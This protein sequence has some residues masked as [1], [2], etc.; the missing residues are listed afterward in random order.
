[1]RRIVSSDRDEDRRLISALFDQN[2]YLATYPDVPTAVSPL[3]HYFSVGWREGR[4]PSCFFDTNFYLQTNPD[5]AEAGINPLLHYLRFGAFEGRRPRPTSSISLGDLYRYAPISDR[6]GCDR[7]TPIDRIFIENFLQQHAEHIRGKVLEIGDARYTSKFGS[8][9]V[10][11]DVLDIDPTNQRANIIADLQN[12]PNI[13]DG[14]YDCI[15]LTQV[16]QYVDDVHAA[17]RTL[18]RIL[19]PGG[20]LLLTVPGITPA[21]PG[22]P[23]ERWFWSF[24]RRAIQ[25]LLSPYFNSEELVIQSHGNLALSVAF[26]AGLAREELEPA[27]FQHDDDNY[28]LVIT[29]RAF[30]PFVAGAGLDSDS[31]SADHDSNQSSVDLLDQSVKAL[32]TK[33][34]QR[35]SE[36]DALEREISRLTILARDLGFSGKLPERTTARPNRGMILMY[37]RVGLV[38]PDP[39]GLC[40][41]PEVFRAQMEHLARTCDPLPLEALADAASTGH[42]PRHAVA[43][44][45]DDGYLDAF[46]A[47]DILSALQIPVTFFVNSNAGGETFVDSLAR[48]F[49]GAHPL[50][51]E[52]DLSR[53]GIAR[54]FSCA[55]PE[56]RGSTLE[57][58]RELGFSLSSDGRRELVGILRRWSDVD[59]APRST[60][61]LLMPAELRELANRPGHSIGAHTHH[62]LYLPAQPRSVKIWEI[63]TNRRYLQ[64]VLGRELS[65]FAYPYGAFD[66]ETVRICRGMGFRAAVTVISDPVRPWTDPLLLPRYEVKMQTALEFEALVDGACP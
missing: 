8:S 58:L 43:I 62:H 30:K 52:L 31:C 54:R 41:A 21:F 56:A 29:A 5:V 11:S 33:H 26:L 50:P 61:R 16:L 12:A 34:S 1:M 39:A 4:N 20:T 40:L 57:A 65:S 23:Y 36:L 25:E 44:T 22:P 19:K 48:I 59:M 42:I 47:S 10:Q 2:Y 60:H 3:E 53:I 38:A 14:I 51:S 9:V 55:T 32:E 64:D 6:W 63:A 45:L 27:D 13:N 24:H 46:T 15:I 17:V 66:A 7:G 49:L 37:H 18:H 28:D 35:E